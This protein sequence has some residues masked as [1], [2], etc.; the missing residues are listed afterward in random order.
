MKKLFMI[1][2]SL[3]LLITTITTAAEIKGA[4]YDS[5]LNPIQNTIIE[6]NTE[7]AQKYLAKDGSY[8]FQVSQGT[9][10]L[11]AKNTESKILTEENIT[12]VNEGQFNVDL[13]V[14]EN[15]DDLNQILTDTNNIAVEETPSYNIWTILIIAGLILITI[16]Y[17]LKNKQNKGKQFSQTEEVEIT[18]T[19]EEQSSENDLNKILK[20]IKQENGRIS[21]KELR[22]HF[23][24]SEAKIS[25]MITELEHKNKIEKI[26]KG[27]TNVII[28]K[29]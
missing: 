15:T 10:L 14:F 7:P 28:L 4:I 17:V 24:L 27:R 2:L 16:S 19:K 9:Y 3:I 6:I 25:L 21:Q 26:K 23:P 20:I 18:E 8:A 12:I 13:F 29:D 22:K 11:T 1:T 5:S